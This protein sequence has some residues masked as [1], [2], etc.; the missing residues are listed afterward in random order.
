[1]KIFYFFIFYLFQKISQ[2]ILLNN[3]LKIIK[4]DQKYL[5]INKY[6]FHLLYLI[7][8]NSY[9]IIQFLSHFACKNQT[10]SKC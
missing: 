10:L 1:M 6:I 2:W 5:N 8:K 4:I 3:L 7:S 9:N